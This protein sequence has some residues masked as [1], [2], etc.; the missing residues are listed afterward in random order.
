MSVEIRPARREELAEVAAL[1]AQLVRM[2][3][4]LDPARFFLPERVA[5]G[6][7]WWFGKELDRPEVV[8]LV[9]VQ[10]A[11]IVGYA[12]GRVEE[13]DYNML[14]DAHGALHDVWVEPTAR[15]A[16]VA[17]ALVAAV[18][19]ALTDKGAPRVLL[20]TASQNASAQALFRSLGFR[21]TMIE[22]TREA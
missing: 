22:M 2:H 13:R 15:R 1:A 4:E 3:H 10:D 14:L 12:Y 7:A 9:A 6:Y 17:K 8:L 11:R 16:G 21:P 19:Q 18:V 5:E 20:H